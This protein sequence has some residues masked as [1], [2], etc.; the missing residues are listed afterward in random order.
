MAM[1]VKDRICRLDDCENLLGSANENQLDIA[2]NDETAVRDIL[3]KTAH[4]RS[5][6]Q[7]AAIGT[8]QNGNGNE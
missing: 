4:G 2:Q 5:I 1:N 7:L 3:T 8:L 6:F